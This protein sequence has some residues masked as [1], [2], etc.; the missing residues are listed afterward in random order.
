MKRSFVFA[1]LLSQAWLAEAFVAPSSFA[2]CSCKVGDLGFSPIH[3]SNPSR[4]EVTAMFACN[5]DE[6]ELAGNKDEERPF[7]KFLKNNIP[8]FVGILALITLFSSLV[9]VDTGE[10]GIV[11]QLGTLSQLDP[12]L[13]Y[14]PPLISDVD[15]LST[16]TT[17]L[18]QSN[19]V[20][21]REGLSVELDTAILFRLNADDGLNLYASV[22]PAYESKLVAPE[23]SSA[24]RGLTS[25]SEAKALYTSGRT[26]VQ[27]RLK[28]ELSTSLNPRGIIIE[29]VLLKAVVLPEDLSK[30]IEEKA[31]AEQDSAR[32]EFVLQKEHQEAERKSIEAEGIADFQRIVTKGITPSLLQ[33][34]GIEATEKL[35]ESSNAKIVIIGNNKDSLPVILGGG[36]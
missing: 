18:E 35:A 31:R 13:H 22:G 6:E 36:N 14:V 19:F 12:G 1:V 23:A 20:P 3:K 28:S 5:K 11:S 24:V 4:F 26:E 27:N 2:A 15:F 32:M 10:I 8:T 30:S 25:E 34:K 29:D 7:S 21:T 9:V 16:K 33:W 17:L